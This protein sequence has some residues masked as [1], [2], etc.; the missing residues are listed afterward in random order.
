MRFNLFFTTLLVFSFIQFSVCQT[1]KEKEERIKL[2][3][4]PVLAQS[5]VELLPQKC[6]RL[7]F[8][9]ETDGNKQS[10]EAKFKY[11]RE[12][13]SI[14]FA[15]NGIVEDIEV[16][17]KFKSIGDSIEKHIKGYFKAS[18][19]KY[20]VIKIQQQFVYSKDLD[21]V[22]FVRNVISKNSKI[23]PKFEIIAEVKTENERTIREFT[24]NKSG[25]F[26]SFRF[27]NTTSYEH[28]L[29]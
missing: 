21:T 24:F 11:K 1:K 18:F 16:I 26:I 20:K 27:L 9:K 8:Y 14:E 29:Y 15:K 5:V 19:V 25:A 28:V 17:T 12:Y 22:E 6:K 4:F 2:S 7:K 23:Y 13:Y 10:F 3:E